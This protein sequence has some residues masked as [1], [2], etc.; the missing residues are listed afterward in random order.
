MRRFIKK[1]IHQP[2]PRQYFIVKRSNIWK[3]GNWEV[4]FFTLWA[5]SS[6][7]QSYQVFSLHSLC[8]WE[9]DRSNRQSRLQ[10]VKEFLE[11]TAAKLQGAINFMI[12]MYI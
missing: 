10:E 11:R 6:S 7:L 1:Y 3:D 12:Y 8:D 2:V 5:V 4:E 9:L